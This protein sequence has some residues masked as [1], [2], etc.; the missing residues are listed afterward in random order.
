VAQHAQHLGL[1]FDCRKSSLWTHTLNTLL[2]KIFFYTF[3]AGRAK[4]QITSVPFTS[5]VGA[6]NDVT[7]ELKLDGTVCVCVCV[8]TTNLTRH[9]QTEVLKQYI[10]AAFTTVDAQRA[11]ILDFVVRLL[12]T[13]SDS[14]IRLGYPISAREL[15]NS[16]LPSTNG[17]RH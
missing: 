13:L 16:R 10:T 17:T 8:C 4:E 2:K 14:A 6:G 15:G 1:N 12:S 9:K 11:V 5:E 3:G 7:P